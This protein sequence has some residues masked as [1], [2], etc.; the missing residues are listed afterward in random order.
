MV[1]TPIQPLWLNI[2]AINFQKQYTNNI[3]RITE[4]KKENAVSS[5]INLQCEET[6]VLVPES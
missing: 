1:L 6:G 5:A 2:R 4:A 3:I